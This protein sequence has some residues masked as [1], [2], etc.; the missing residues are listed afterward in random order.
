MQSIHNLHYLL[1]SVQSRN[2]APHMG[3]PRYFPE[4][5]VSAPRYKAAS[6]LG[7]AALLLPTHSAVREGGIQ[8]RGKSVPREGG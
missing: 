1:F 5:L 8:E 6:S 4:S 7:K 2:E 3:I